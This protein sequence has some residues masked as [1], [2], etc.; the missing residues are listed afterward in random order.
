MARL[1]SSLPSVR[2][3]VLGDSG[4][5]KTSLLLSLAAPTAPL[6]SSLSSSALSSVRSTIGCTP[7]T[8]LLP[9]VAFVELFDVGGHRKYALSR[10]TFYRDIDGLLLVFDCSNTK[11][12]THISR[13]IAELVQHT[14][15]PHHTPT[16]T[17]STTAPN[18]TTHHP[19]THRASAHPTDSQRS[20]EA[21]AAALSSL[22]VLAVGTKS[23]LVDGRALPP[24]DSMRDY[25][26]DMVV[27]SAKK[28]GADG[29]L[30]S[31]LP[32]FHRVLERRA[33]QAAIGS[34]PTH[35]H[36]RAHSHQLNSL[37]HT[38]TA[39]YQRKTHSSTNNRIS[40]GSGNGRSNGGAHYKDERGWDTAGEEE[41]EGGGGGGWRRGDGGEVGEEE[42]GD[43]GMTIDMG[44]LDMLSAYNSGGRGEAGNGDSAAASKRFLSPSSSSPSSS[45]SGASPP[46]ARHLSPLSR[47]LPTS[48]F[49]LG[50]KK[51]DKQARARV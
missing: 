23:D 43:G 26:L 29:P 19:H 9:S 11:S 1:S 42:D 18:H 32:F 14:T 30:S 2:I 37:T 47:L 31:L 44:Q 7:H 45:R 15:D 27:V 24:F 39:A 49:G 51:E 33:E 41:E 46:S 20:I 28:A 13:W 6:A 34:R 17:I 50:A 10:S 36:A 16:T 4:V 3:L 12:Y 40:G 25:G 35:V 21:T 8:L 38:T 48:L 5:G 22:P